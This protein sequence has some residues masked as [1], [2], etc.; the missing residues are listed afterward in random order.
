MGELI[1]VW[2]QTRSGWFESGFPVPGGVEGGRTQRQ[3][4]GGLT[5]KGWIRQGGRQW[6]VG[7]RVEGRRYL[8][9]AVC[10]RVTLGTLVPWPGK[11]VSFLGDTVAGMLL[12][13][14]CRQDG[15][16]GAGKG[17][18]GLGG[19]SLTCG[20]CSGEVP[21]GKVPARQSRVGRVWVVSR[22]PCGIPARISGR[23]DRAR[24]R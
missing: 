15:T 11:T 8:S 4:V 1:A 5:Q 24:E 18:G 3:S 10:E 16:A 19:R 12:R 13:R 20:V 22:V 9:L 7:G 21:L 17:R 6:E 2:R 23:A 14:T